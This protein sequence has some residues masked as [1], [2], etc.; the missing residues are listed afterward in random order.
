MAPDD[1]TAEIADLA[2]T[3]ARVEEVIDVGAAERDIAEL[4]V[5]ASAA[6]SLWTTPPAPSR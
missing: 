4:E 2:A 5:S 6:G 3:L 1:I